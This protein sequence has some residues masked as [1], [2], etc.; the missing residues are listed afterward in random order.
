MKPSIRAIVPAVA[1]IAAAQGCGSGT[2]MQQAC[3]SLAQAQCA[4]RMSCSNAIDATGASVVRSFGTLAACETREELACMNGLAAPKS[5]NTVATVEE[6]VA[7]FPAY[8]C[9]DFFN[10]NP[11]AA[12]APTGPGPNGTSCAFNAQCTSGY[13]SGTKYA[14][15]GTCAMPPAPGDSCATSACGHDQVCV[16]ASTEC[17]PEGAIGAAC[18]DA[19]PCGDGS[20]CVGNDTATS[21]PGICMT[22]IEQ[23]S[24]P[25][26][27]NT[28]AACDGTEGLFCG[29]TAGAKTCMSI[30]Y[31]GDGMPCGDLTSTSHAECIAGGCY[32]KTGP[33]GS[34]DMG[35]CKAD[36]TDGSPC[37]TA[38]GPSC[39]TPARCVVAGSTTA[40][41]CTVPTGAACG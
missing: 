29:G 12:C 8:A 3:Q 36:V 6:C 33:A 23:M 1:W 39:Q 16:G 25:C 26:G 21:T 24:S 34:G 35:T 11:P 30:T 32:T 27:G 7:A 28:M 40:G 9:T 19:D 20:S 4:K 14:I 22:S 5:G 10:G 31:V 18:D 2:T 15:C 38:L 17:E 41:T 37:D 13:C